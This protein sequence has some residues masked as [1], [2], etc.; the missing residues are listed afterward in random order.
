MRRTPTQPLR[1]PLIDLETVRDTLAYM[2][3][4]LKRVAGMERAAK[5]LAEAIDEIAVADSRRQAVS[6]GIL[7]ARFLRRPRH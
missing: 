2:H 6:Y 3:D 1:V 5:A 4:D 7:G